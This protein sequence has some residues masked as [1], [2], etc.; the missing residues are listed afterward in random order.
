MTKGFAQAGGAGS[1]G[2][3]GRVW[4]DYVAAAAGSVVGGYLIGWQL[5][6]WALASGSGILAFAS[7]WQILLIPLGSAIGTVLALAALRRQSAVFTGVLTLA[8]MFVVWAIVAFLAMLV[9]A[10]GHGWPTVASMVVAPL[11]ARFIVLGRPPSESERSE[12]ED[13]RPGWTLR[14]WPLGRIVRYGVPVLLAASIVVLV[15]Y[16]P[17]PAPEVVESQYSLGPR[18][19]ECEILTEWVEGLPISPGFRASTL[20]V[21]ELAE[22]FVVDVRQYA[23]DDFDLDYYWT[24]FGDAGFTGVRLFDQPDHQSATFFEGDTRSE[25]PWIVDVTLREANID[26]TF[27]IRVDGSEWGIASTD[28]LWHVYTSNRAAAEE[29]HIERQESAVEVV[30]SF[31]HALEDVRN[32]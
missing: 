21:S 6:D 25:S 11:G 13:A 24:V 2:P 14:H 28:D 26:M 5:V 30:D 19:C 32:A 1:Q 17:E 18:V 23:G 16:W 8:V 12:P 15:I 9:D 29:I 4:V 27:R 22:G 31:R 3:L 10:T 7:L 20:R